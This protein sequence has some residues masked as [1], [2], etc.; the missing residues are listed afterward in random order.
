MRQSFD[1]IEYNKFPGHHYY[2]G[3]API[4][5]VWHITGDTGRY[6]V[7]CKTNRA[8][9]IGCFTAATLADISRELRSR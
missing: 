9:G 2:V 1:N 7:Y 6:I 3:Y 4:S 5:G 8:A